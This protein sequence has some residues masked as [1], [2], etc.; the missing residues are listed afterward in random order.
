MLEWIKTDNPLTNLIIFVHVL[1]SIFSCLFCK[2]IA[3]QRAYLIYH[4]P[5]RLTVNIQHTIICVPLSLRALCCNV[6]LVVLSYVNWYWYHQKEHHVALAR[7][8]SLLS[9]HR[10][11]Q[12]LAKRFFVTVWM[13]AMVKWLIRGRGAHFMPF[14]FSVR[15]WWKKNEENVWILIKW[16]AF[17]CT[18]LAA[19]YIANS[20]IL[21]SFYLTHPFRTCFHYPVNLCFFFPCTYF[22]FFWSRSRTRSQF[23]PGTISRPRCS[24]PAQCWN[25]LHFWISAP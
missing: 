9:I 11:T 1:F 15:Q 8:R 6:H 10:V 18:C 14:K 13:T 16:P 23:Q 12:N 20:S 2:C 4:I 19:L 7:A 5:S 24:R 22:L 17:P 21:L 25:L 3:H